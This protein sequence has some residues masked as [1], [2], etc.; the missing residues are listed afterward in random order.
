MLRNMWSIWCPML[1]LIPEKIDKV[2]GSYSNP[3]PCYSIC[4]VYF[5]QTLENTLLCCVCLCILRV[6]VS[7]SAVTCCSLSL[8]TNVT[9]LQ[10][11][12]TVSVSGKDGLKGQFGG[13]ESYHTRM[14]THTHVHMHPDTQCNTCSTDL[15]AQRC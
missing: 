11:T 1:P 14:H 3:P 8:Q 12:V 7:V 4:L 9:H 15:K 10:T 13:E 5:I 6:V 2:L